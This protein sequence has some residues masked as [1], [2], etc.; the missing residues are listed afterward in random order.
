MA[1]EIFHLER[2]L[3]EKKRELA[4]A[5]QAVPPEKE[6]LREILKEQVQQARTAVPASP[7]DTTSL[8]SAAPQD[9]ATLRAL[10][11]RD[12]ER[13]EDLRTL[14]EIAL[15]KDLATAVKAAEETSPYLLD[16]LHDHLVDEYYQKLVELRK[17]SAL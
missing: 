1:E 7:A 9:D 3:E 15:T 4:E 2:Q 10:K 6:V 12:E 17:L 5:G 14:I 8:P 16:E 13:A 11:K